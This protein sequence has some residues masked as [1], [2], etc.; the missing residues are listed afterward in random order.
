MTP[1]ILL[2]LQLI[3]CSI[4]SFFIFSSENEKDKES[5][6]GDGTDSED[7]SPEGLWVEKHMVSVTTFCL[8]TMYLNYDLFIPKV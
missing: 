8:I 3:F 1:G 7:L 2:I 6:E 5:S 4:I